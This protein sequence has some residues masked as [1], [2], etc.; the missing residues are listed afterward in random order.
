METLSS[1]VESEGLDFLVEEARS[2]P[3][4]II[5]TGPAT[6]VA[7]M[8]L[9]APKSGKTSGR[10]ARGF[11]DEESYERFKMGGELNGRADVAAWR[12]L[13]EDSVDLLQ[14]P[15]WSG[16]H[17]L[18]VNGFAFAEELRTLGNHV[19]DYLADI[20]VAWVG[21]KGGEL[22]PEEKILW[23]VSC[24][25]AV[26]DPEAVTIDRLAVP[27]LDAAG[28]H[29]F[30]QRGREVDVLTDLD[31]ERVLKSMVAALERHR[32]ARGP[33]PGWSTALSVPVF[34][35]KDVLT[36]K[37]KTLISFVLLALSCVV[38]TACGS[39]SGADSVPGG[40]GEKRP[41]PELEKAAKGHGRQLLYVGR[42][43]R[44]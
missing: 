19:A 6:D 28:A 37:P 20:L 29:D 16:P 43:Q 3:L 39:G 32:Q 9:V 15:G 27:A 8:L 18:A 21:K 12:A 34:S 33:D 25:T 42:G 31:E 41:F 30:S 4:T 1:P 17:K 7:S 26:S 13:F 38:F 11:G 24:I 40:P 2:G 5:A 36:L 44:D 22:G 35:R 10:M 23:D 14:V